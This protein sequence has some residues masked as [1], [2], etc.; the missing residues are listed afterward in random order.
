MADYGLG[1]TANFYTKHWHSEHFYTKQLQNNTILFFLS[2]FVDS[3][4]AKK[5][6][7]GYSYNK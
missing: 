7:I 2:R 5:L 1:Y 4:C 3:H 6:A